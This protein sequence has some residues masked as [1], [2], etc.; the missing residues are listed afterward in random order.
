MRRIDA[1]LMS[2][3]SSNCTGHQNLR[4]ALKLLPYSDQSRS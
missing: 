3:K 1:Q 2:N 4:E